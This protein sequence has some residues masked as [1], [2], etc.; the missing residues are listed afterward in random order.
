MSKSVFTFRRLLLLGFLLGSSCMVSAQDAVLERAQHIYE[1]FVA[2]QGDSIHARLNKKMQEKVAPALFSDPIRQAEAMFGK[3]QSQGEWQK[4]VVQGIEIYYCDLKLERYTLRFLLA[5]DADGC[6]NTIRLMPAPTESIPP[7]RTQPADTAGIV[8]REI[9]VG[10]EGFRLPGTLTLPR[11][12]SV[13]SGRKLPCV[14]LVH[15][16]GPNDRDETIGPNKPFRDIAYGLARRGIAVI[17]YDKRTKVYASK[18]AP[19]GRE[20]DYDTEATDDAVAAVA[21][22]KSLPQVAA[23]SIYVL[24]HSLGGTLAPRIAQRAP[25][26]AGIIILAGLARP[27][28][29]TLLDQYRYIFSLTGSTPDT[30]KQLADLQAQMENVK[31]LDTAEFDEKVPLLLNVPASYWRMALAYKPVEV[32]AELKLPM[33]V[34]QG[35]RDYQVTMEDFGLWRFGLLRCKNAVFKSYPKLNHLMQEGIGKATP[36]EYNRASPVALYVVEDI[37]EFVRRKSI[38]MD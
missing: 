35:E 12:A 2:G 5:F 26:L 8:E 33:L 37:A 25:D 23:D 17:R 1:L 7:A 6:I 24:G 21:Q 3:L 4:D 30:E 18:S 20:L 14:I 29:D 34:L 32:A 28:E 36:M 19:Q 9:T 22:A 13:S 10:A 11:T 15:G 27:L 38:R 16:S 31:K